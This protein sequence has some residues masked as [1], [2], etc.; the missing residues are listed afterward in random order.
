MKATTQFF[1]LSPIVNLDA[2][3]SAMTRRKSRIEVSTQIPYTDE[4]GRT[5]SVYFRLIDACPN[6]QTDVSCDCY[7]IEQVT[8]KGRKVCLSSNG[9]QTL[10]TWLNDV[11]PSPR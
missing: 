4:H 9:E 3:V 6:A 10:L 2:F 11:Q 1:P 5:V 7:T 8:F